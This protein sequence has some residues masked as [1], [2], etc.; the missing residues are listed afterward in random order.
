MKWKLLPKAGRPPFSLFDDRKVFESWKRRAIEHLRTPPSSDWDW[1]AIAQH[2]G[3]ATRLL[4]WTTNPLN[5]AYFA[6]R[7]VRKADAVVYA[8]RFKW[9]VDPEA[10]SPMDFSDVAKFWP[11]GVVPRIAR[12]AGLFTVHGKPDIPLE[13]YSEGLVA[14]T[15]IVIPKKA[16]DLLLRE[17]SYYGINAASLFPDLDGLSTF[18][19]WTMESREYWKLEIDETAQHK[20]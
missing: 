11:L 12:Q 9:R 8:A 17:L 14:L 10:V 2:H 19:N 3:L 20:S 15:E 18:L 7:E 5:A 16:R 4:D 13:E 6:V 1:L